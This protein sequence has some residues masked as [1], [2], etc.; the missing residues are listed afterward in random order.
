MW[1]GF[2]FCIQ[3]SKPES[4]G[5]KGLKQE[6]E[7]WRLSNSIILV[8]VLRLE[9]SIFVSFWLCRPNR[10]PH[11]PLY[12][13]GIS[14]AKE[15]SERKLYQ[16]QLKSQVLFQMDSLG[17]QEEAGTQRIWYQLWKQQKHVQ[18]QFHGSRSLIQWVK[19]LRGEWKAVSDQRQWVVLKSASPG[20]E[21]GHRP[22]NL[23]PYVGIFWMVGWWFLRAMGNVGLQRWLSS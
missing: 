10:F 23:R 3:K 9:P 12:P 6:W 17:G 21:D 16:C 15:R 2:W 22:E 20:N 11:Y 8:P 13:R 18:G 19:H 14:E 5:R 7:S 1:G 4:G